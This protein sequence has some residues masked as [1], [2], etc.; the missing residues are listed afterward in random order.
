MLFYSS[1]FSLPKRHIQV[2]KGTARA[3]R[4]VFTDHNLTSNVASKMSQHG[5]KPLAERSRE[6]RLSLLYKIINDPVTT[7]ADSPIFQYKK[8]T[9]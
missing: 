8:H 5:W 6:H 1:V 3:G 4:F 2:R 9:N 7:P